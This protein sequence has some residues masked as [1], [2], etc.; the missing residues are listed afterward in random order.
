MIHRLLPRSLAGRTAVFLT[1]ALMMVQAAGLTIHALDRVDLQRFAL[2]REISAR[3]FGVW[4]TVLLAPPD[5]REAMLYDI[6]LPPGLIADLSD[7]PAVRP[8]MPR[9]SASLVR[10]FRLD[11]VTAG[12]ARFRPREALVAGGPRPGM[13]VLAMQL[14]DGLWLNMRMALPPPRPWHSET[15]LFAF[16]LMTGA[17]LAL[18][19]WATRRLTRPVSALARAAE[20]LGRDV[21][22]PPLPE[23]G[24]LEVATAARAFNTMAERIRRFVGDRTQMLAAIGH[25][26]RTPITRLRLRAEFLEDEEQRRKMLADLD[27]MEAMVNATLA[28]A[29]DDSAT[30]PSV[31]LDLAALCRTV[32][33]EAADA[34][35]ELAPETTAYDGPERL[36]VRGRPIA[37]K[38]ALANLVGNALNY[39]GSARLRLEGPGTGAEAA[40][41]RLR[42]EDDGPGIPEESLETVFQPFRRLETSRNR[43]T[44][45][46]GLGLPIA[47]NILRAHGGDVV[48]RNRPG[49]GLTALVT[50]PV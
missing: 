35:P 16:A 46:T 24:P 39:G 23:N 32:L 25:D 47:R 48:L 41:L 45:G 43:E 1:L 30:E 18:I 7:L 50:L 3:A 26:L 14:P 27:E 38:R 49:G 36:R 5:R 19:L 21:N 12:P 37:L 44:G 28:F 34:R 17:A 20:R 31:P 4:R 22:A 10:L 9:A 15:F 11:L 33:D 40:L 29:R 8:G 42:V 2:S 13:L 6:D